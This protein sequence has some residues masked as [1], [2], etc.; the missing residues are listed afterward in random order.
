MAKLTKLDEWCTKHTKAKLATELGV[1]GTC[2]AHW[3]NR[4]HVPA[5]KC[6]AVA[7]VTRIAK[8]HL[9]PVFA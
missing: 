3:I 8:R 4:G 9:N 2:V 6:E 1:T 5:K 7:R